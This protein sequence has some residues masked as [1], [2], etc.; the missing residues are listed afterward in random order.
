MTVG[1]PS[2]FMGKWCMDSRQFVAEEDW[3]QSIGAEQYPALAYTHATTHP[4]VTL[5]VLESGEPYE[6]HMS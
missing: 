5:D 2:S 4:D 1:A 3:A 6:I